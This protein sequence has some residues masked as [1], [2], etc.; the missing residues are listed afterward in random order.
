M[1]DVIFMSD[2]ERDFPSAQSRAK[3]RFKSGQKREKVTFFQVFLPKKIK[4][5]KTNLPR[6]NLASG[7]VKGGLRSP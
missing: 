2:C 4:E 3:S 5:K 6:P 1:S 7:E